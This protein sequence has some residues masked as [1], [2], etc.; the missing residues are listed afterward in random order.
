MFIGIHRVIAEHSTISESES[1]GY[2]DTVN[3][4]YYAEREDTSNKQQIQQF[5]S[6]SLKKKIK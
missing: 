1:K 4:D 3:F 6:S 5:I 2:S